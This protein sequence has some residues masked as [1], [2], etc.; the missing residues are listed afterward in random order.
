[1]KITLNELRSLV[2]QMI[3]EE[4]KK[5]T[6]LKIDGEYITF[7]KQNDKGII[8]VYGEDQNGEPY[9]DIS[10]NLPDNPLVDAIWVEVGGDE[11]KIANKL[12]FLTK[13]N[14]TAKSGY[15]KYIMYN[16]K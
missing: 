12:N 15:N 7:I 3:K 4:T 2:K 14:R 10:T 5:L 9:I 13:T 16:V 8:Y 11:E 6:K 1:M